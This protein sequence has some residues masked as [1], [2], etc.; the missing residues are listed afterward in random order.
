[1]ATCRPQLILGL[2][3]RPSWG[4]ARKNAGRPRTSKLVAHEKR[5]ELSKHHPV[6]VT[7]RVRADI[8]NLRNRS[9]FIAVR[10]ALRAGR[11]REGFRLVHF[12][13]QSNHLHLIA[14]AEDRLSLARGIQ[15]LKIRIARALN[16][17]AKRKGAVFSDRYHAHAL[18]TPRETRNAIAYVLL[19]ARK[20]AN[21]R[22][23]TNQVDSCSS[24]M[25][26]DGW[27]EKV[28]CELEVPRDL[29][30]DAKTWLMRV[31]WRKHGPIS[32]SETPA[33]A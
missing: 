23:P 9:R 31:G 6:H 19:N 5:P 26:F 29:I 33:F 25:L 32:A 15:A 1:M 8:S 22:A 20:H 21:D 18:K 28:C 3:P 17:H 14:E 30:A 2:K 4:G 11:E 12:S 27:R 24:A 13:V 16:A 10:N 7:L